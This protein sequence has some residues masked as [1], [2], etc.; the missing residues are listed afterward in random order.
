[1]SYFN[2][3]GFSEGIP[4][5]LMLFDLPPT[6]EAVDNVYYHEIRP[7]S[8]VSEKHTNRISNQWSKFYGLFGFKRNPAVCKTEGV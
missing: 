4:E 2:E 5:S 1:M 8:Q 6:Q 3:E 7:T